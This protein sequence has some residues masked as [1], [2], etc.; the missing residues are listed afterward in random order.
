LDKFGDL[1]HFCTLF[2]KRT[3]WRFFEKRGFLV[4]Q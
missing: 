3:V 1:C 4:L 2:G